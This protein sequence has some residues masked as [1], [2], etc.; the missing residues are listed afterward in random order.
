M[1]RSPTVWKSWEL[2]M[3]PQVGPVLVWMR[4]SSTPQQIAAKVE[5]LSVL[6]PPIVAIP[7]C[8]YSPCLDMNADC[9]VT[10]VTTRD[11]VCKFGFYQEG[12][13]CAGPHSVLSHCPTLTCG[14]NECAD[15]PACSYFACP[16][17]SRCVEQTG[18]PNSTAG[19]TCECN[20]GYEPDGAGACRG[21]DKTSRS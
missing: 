15:I 10:G 2:Q 13:N 20:E 14:T 21:H 8:E 3:G 12:S 11:C 19:R 18:A 16:A 4:I 6:L 9:V 7:P 1:T 17:F 5:P